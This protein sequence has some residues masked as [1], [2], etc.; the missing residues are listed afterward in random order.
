LSLRISKFM[1]RDVACRARRSAVA[2]DWAATSGD[3]T[4][5]IA[6]VTSHI[7]ADAIE[8]DAPQRLPAGST[9]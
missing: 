7:A 9:H 8:Q 2:A 3:K 6:D 1:R 4:N 5:Q